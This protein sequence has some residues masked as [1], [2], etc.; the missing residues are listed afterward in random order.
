MQVN[1]VVACGNTPR[2]ATTLIE[3]GNTLSGKFRREFEEL[4]APMAGEELDRHRISAFLSC[5]GGLVNDIARDSVKGVLEALDRP[6]ASVTVQGERLRYR[7]LA[8]KRWLSMFGKVEVRRRVYRGDGPNAAKCVPLDAASG[9][10]DRFMLPDVEDLVA[11]T[12]A[13]VPQREAEQLLAKALPKGPSA[14]AMR[15]A[16]KTLGGELADRHAAVEEAIDR[17]APLSTD[18]DV[19]ALSCDGVMVAMREEGA[20]GWREASAATISVYGP[21]EETPERLDVRYFA[22]MP[23]SRMETLFDRAV[24]EVVRAH[25]RHSYRETVVICDGCP[26]LWT[27]VQS[28]A[29]L[30]SATHILDFYHASENLMK[31]AKAI[32]G[33]TAAAHRWHKK[34]RFNLQASSKGVTQAIRSMRRYKAKLTSESR[35]QVVHNVIGYFTNNRERMDYASFLERGLP[36]GS[37]PVEAA[38]KTIVQARLK[39]SGMRWSTNG[40]QHVLDLRTHLKSNRWQAMWSALKSAA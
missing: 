4:V 39:R 9:M 25:Q 38:A 35:Q 36:I 31:A 23:E 13:M 15:N 10:D 34:Y 29:E 30:N 5:L 8:P 14:T 17:S 33:D 18:G 1:K 7:G 21:G 19:L 16:V 32:F 22:R 37:G 12:M 27:Q 20:T 2:P 26:T 6:Q 11:M 24:H 40:G 3:L 28:R